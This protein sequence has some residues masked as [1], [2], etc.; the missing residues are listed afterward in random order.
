MLQISTA[1]SHVTCR[2]PH[3]SRPPPSCLPSSPGFQLPFATQLPGYHGYCSPLDVLL[4]F[5]PA[6]TALA[7]VLV[8]PPWVSCCHS[9]PDGSVRMLSF[10]RS[11]IH[12]LTVSIIERSLQIS[13]NAKHK[14]RMRNKLTSLPSFQSSDPSK[15]TTT[16]HAPNPPHVG[17]DLS[18]LLRGSS[19]HLT[20]LSSCSSFKAEAPQS[21]CSI[22]PSV[23]L[24]QRTQCPL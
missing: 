2:E 11:F 7:Q 8:T 19:P 17:S 16:G 12:S 24:L 23:A 13:D 21:T 4:S 5:A 1:T 3:S 18:F 14:E 22:H 9:L 15:P 20:L 10:I 6:P